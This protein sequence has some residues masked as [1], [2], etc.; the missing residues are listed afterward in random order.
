MNIDLAITNLINCSTDLNVKEKLV[1]LKSKI[2]TAIPE[3]T[4]KE[5]TKTMQ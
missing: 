5:K 3:V 2:M 4:A 1:E